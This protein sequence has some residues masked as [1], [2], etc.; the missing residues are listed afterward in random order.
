VFYL[1]HLDLQHAAYNCESLE[2]SG[3]PAVSP[4]QF[5]GGGDGTNNEGKKEMLY[6][7]TL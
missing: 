6:F 4:P 3:S 1:F 5:E 2:G 7:L